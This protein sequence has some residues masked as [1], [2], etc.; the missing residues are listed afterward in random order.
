MVTLRCCSAQDVLGLSSA[1]SWVKLSSVCPACA[2]VLC[3][4]LLSAKPELSCASL[5]CLVPAPAWVRRKMLTYIDTSV[6]RNASEKKINSL[7]DF[8]AQV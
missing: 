5:N 8:M 1:C 6:T 7:L 3:S 4:A 2:Q